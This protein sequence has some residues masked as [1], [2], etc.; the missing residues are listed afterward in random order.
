MK[1]TC[2][3][4]RPGMTVAPFRLMVRPHGPSAPPRP[5]STMRPSRMPIAETTLLCASSVRK[6]P[7]TRLRSREPSHSES[8]PLESCSLAARAALASSVPL[9]A[10]AAALCMNLRRDKPRCFEFLR[11]IGAPPLENYLVLRNCTGDGTDVF[12]RS[13]EHTSELQSPMY[14]VC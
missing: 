9:A 7:L 2:E 6:R 13:E 14:L 8:C 11:A 1:C 3:S 5:I 10:I 4:M 12:D